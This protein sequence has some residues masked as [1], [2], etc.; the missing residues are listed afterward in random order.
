M[1]KCHVISAKRLGWEQMYDYYTFPVDEYSKEDA[2][3]QFFTVQ[4]E[5]TKANGQSY[6]YTAYEYNGEIYH[7]IIYSGIADDSEFD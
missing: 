2:M 7:S 4:K 3:N 5:T 6:P 1:G